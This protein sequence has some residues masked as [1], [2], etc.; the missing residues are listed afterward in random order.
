MPST[1]SQHPALPGEPPALSAL[2]VAPEGKAVA[3][4]ALGEQAQRVSAAV[5][6]VARATAEGEELAVEAR[7]P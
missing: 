6:L 7:V 3:L 4:L 2:A 5:P 1:Q